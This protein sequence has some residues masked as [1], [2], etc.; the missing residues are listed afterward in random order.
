MPTVEMRVL[1][2]NMLMI[3]NLRG[4]RRR[5]G[6]DRPATFV[7]RRYELRKF[8]MVQLYAGGAQIVSAGYF[9]VAI[10]LCVRTDFL[11]HRSFLHDT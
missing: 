3:G 11:T 1:A 6:R 9:I 7:Q 8:Y 5:D 4:F 10:S 2:S